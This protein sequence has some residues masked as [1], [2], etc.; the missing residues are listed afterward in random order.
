[1]SRS[2][3][4]SLATVLDWNTPHRESRVWHPARKRA[5]TFVSVLTTLILLIALCGLAREFL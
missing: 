3:R 5:H 4:R 1:M 2:R